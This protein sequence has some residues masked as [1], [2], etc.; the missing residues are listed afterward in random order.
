MLN[1]VALE[2]WLANLICRKIQKRYQCPLLVLN[3]VLIAF[4]CICQAVLLLYLL[5]MDSKYC[6]K[7]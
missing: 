3:V 4:T 2:A 6:E 5:E 1:L 7:F